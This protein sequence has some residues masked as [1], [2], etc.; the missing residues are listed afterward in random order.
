MKAECGAE[1]YTLTGKE[2]AITATPYDDKLDSEV[3]AEVETALNGATWTEIAQ[4]TANTKET[5]QA[6]LTEQAQA[7][8]N[9][10]KVSVTVEVT[11]FTAAVEG[12]AATTKEGTNGKAIFTVKAEI[13]NEEYTLT[14]Q[15]VVIKARPFDGKLDSEVIEDVKTALTNAVWA[16]IA[17]ETANTKEAAQAQLKTQADRIINNTRVSVTIEATAFEAAVAGSAATTHEGT[18]GKVTFTVYATVGAEEYELGNL[19]AVIK[20]TRFKGVLDKD[21]VKAAQDTLTDCLVTVKIGADAD[22]I[23]ETI[24]KYLDSKMTG[25]ADGVTVTIESVTD[26]QYKLILTKG[27][28]TVEKTIEITVEEEDP[29][30]LSAPANLV[31]ANGVASWDA[32][33]NAVS[34]TVSLYEVVDGTYTLL[35]TAN[36]AQ[37]QCDFNALIEDG[38][39]YA[40][41]V[42]ALGDGVYFLDS[43]VSDFSEVYRKGNTIEQILA[44]LMALRN[45]KYAITAEAGE[46]GVISGEGVTK[47]K[48]GNDITYYIDAM[49]GYEIDCVIVDG[50][51]VG[52]VSEY[53]FE[54]VKKKHTIT[55]TFKEVVWVNPFT[56]VSVADPYYDAVRFVYDCKLFNGISETEFAPQMSMTRAMFVTVLWRLEGMPVVNYLMQYDDVADETWYTEAI[57]WATAEGIVEGYGDGIFG[58]DDAVTV[59][60]ATVI[61]ARYAQYAGTYTAPTANMDIFADNA[62]VADWAVEAMAWAVENGVY[63]PANGKLNPTAMAPRSLAAQFMHAY[64]VKFSK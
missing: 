61:M 9:N 33:A 30:K 52:A 18:N 13:G 40:F 6:K 57:R 58:T 12:T 10:S 36:A 23:R 26:N 64:V 4:D 3:I 19:S 56:D 50:K 31:F 59:Q 53:T 11:D 16:E 51:D 55:V 32:V 5:V 27:G 28:Q 1:E 41:D 22:E 17:Q 2:I 44:V 46:G 62:D 38:K 60:Q 43:D 39:Y 15:E 48:Y 34:Y 47:V 35:T 29:I 37:N 49:P 25:D 63:A 45:S 20:A 7:V 14:A 21:A 42:C 24:E 54:N 8:V